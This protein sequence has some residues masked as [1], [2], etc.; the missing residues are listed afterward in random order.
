M[1]DVEVVHVENLPVVQGRSYRY[2]LQEN[3]FKLLQENGS[4]LLIEFEGAV[5]I[6]RAKQVEQIVHVPSLSSVVSA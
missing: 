2:L 3:G 4:A 5:T 6:T 1:S